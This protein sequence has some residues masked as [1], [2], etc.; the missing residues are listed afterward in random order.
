MLLNYSF[1]FYKIVKDISKFNNLKGVSIMINKIM[2]NFVY[3]NFLVIRNN[4]KPTK[5]QLKK[6][7]RCETVD[8][9]KIKQKDTADEYF[10]EIIIQSYEL[11]NKVIRKDNIC[12]YRV[13]N[14]AVSTLISLRDDFLSSISLTD[15]ECQ[16]LESANMICK[17]ILVARNVDNLELH[18]TLTQQVVSKLRK[19]NNYNVTSLDISPLLQYKSNY[20]SLIYNQEISDIKQLFKNSW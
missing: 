19:S 3:G 6:L 12:I 9:L 13:D 4:E 15:S 7:L 20:G 10:A 14:S 8:E 17:M 18:H 1:S 2:N 5:T 11:L 16:K